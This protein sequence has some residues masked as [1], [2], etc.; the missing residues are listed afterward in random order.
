MF[1][2]QCYA[3]HFHEYFAKC[4]CQTASSTLLIKASTTIQVNER[5]SSTTQRL[6]LRPA[7]H[8]SSPSFFSTTF[9]PGSD[10]ATDPRRLRVACSRAVLSADFII[11][12]INAFLRHTLSNPVKRT[13][14]WKKRFPQRQG[15]QVSWRLSKSCLKNGGLRCEHSSWN[16]SAPLCGLPCAPH[17]SWQ[18]WQPFRRGAHGRPVLTLSPWGPC[19]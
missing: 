7:R 16:D 8:N 17:A 3:R 5:A 11:L 12:S 2:E 1:G 10:Q 18:P 6:P 15:L 13:Q 4:C 19:I 9:T 14:L